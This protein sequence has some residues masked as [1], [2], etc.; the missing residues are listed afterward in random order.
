M[1]SDNELVELIR[2]DKRK[3]LTPIHIELHIDPYNM[4]EDHEV[5]ADERCDFPVAQFTMNPDAIAAQV[6]IAAKLDNFIIHL[7][8]LRATYVKQLGVVYGPLIKDFYNQYSNAYTKKISDLFE[9]RRT[10]VHI[11]TFAKELALREDKD[12]T[13]FDAK[14]IDN[15][16]AD[17][18]G[19]P[20]GDHD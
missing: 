5:L 6:K 18:M 14:R 8:Q 10:M 3:P 16:L 11:H 1:R 17:L 2:A 13:I 20:D 15:E 4:G 19:A 12:E 9:M 7:A